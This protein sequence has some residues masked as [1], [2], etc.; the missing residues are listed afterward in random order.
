MKALTLLMAGVMILLTCTTETKKQPA[1]LDGTWEVVS[2]KRVR[3]DSIIY[4]FPGKITGSEMKIWSGN[5]FI[6]SG[7]Y[8][9]DTLEWD[10]CGGGTFTL[11]ND[12][13][14]ENIQYFPNHEVIGNQSKLILKMEGDTI[15]QTWPADEDW[16]I[17]KTFYNVQ[18]LVKIK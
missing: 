8:R 16:Q 7:H 13:Y 12:H 17:N 5:K 10:N 4:E 3:N 14:T 11:E 18:K 15:T 2:W 9:R 6:F 1:Q